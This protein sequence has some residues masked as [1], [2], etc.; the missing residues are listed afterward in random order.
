MERWESINVSC[1][2][3]KETKV[4]RK[5]GQEGNGKPWK[6]E[7]GKLTAKT[8]DDRELVTL[9]FEDFSCDG[10]EAEV[11]NPKVGD[12]ETGR[13]D[14]GDI[15]NFLKVSVQDLEAKEKENDVGQRGVSWGGEV[16]ERQ[17]PIRTS[18]RP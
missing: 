13:F 4:R 3:T 2:R 5:D 7:E 15:E 12:L 9:S 6:E 14:F 1:S 11:T 18:R 10:W 16:G 8:H 17:L